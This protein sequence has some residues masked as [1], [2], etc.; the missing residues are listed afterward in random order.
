M[1]VAIGDMM[2]TIVVTVV[3]VVNTVVVVFVVVV[4]WFLVVIFF[5]SLFHLWRFCLRSIQSQG[6][7][8]PF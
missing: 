3:T 6:C 5:L 2:V 1:R 8:A 4:P 7:S